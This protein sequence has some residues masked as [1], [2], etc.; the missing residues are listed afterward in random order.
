MDIKPFE[1]PILEKIAFLTIDVIT[2]KSWWDDDYIDESETDS[3]VGYT[4][5]DN[6][7]GDEEW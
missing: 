5:P 4:D 2:Q 1:E 6:P 3:D 7:F